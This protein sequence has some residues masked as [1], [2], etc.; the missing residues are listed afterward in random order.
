[1][2]RLAGGL[3]VVLALAL[4]LGTAPLEIATGLV[5]ALALAAMVRRETRPDADFWP[6]LLLLALLLLLSAAGQS[7]APLPAL[8]A[9][10]EPP[11]ALALLVLLPALP[12]DAEARERAARWGLCGAALV[13]VGALAHAL[14]QGQLPWE[15]PE[16][17]LYS[18]HLTLGYALLPPF[19]AALDRRRWGEALGIAAGVV[20]AGSSGPALAM[21]VIGVGLLVGP[22]VALVGGAL[23]AVGLVAALAADPELHER[24]LLWTSGAQLALGRPMGTSVAGFRE[25][26][27]PVQDALSPSFYFPLHAHDAAL[28]AAAVAGLGAWVLWGWL[29]LLLWRRGGRAGRLALAA[30]LVGGLTQDTL[31][32]LEV[33]RALC[34][35]ALL[36]LPPQGTADGA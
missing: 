31:G 35:W 3:L 7:A 36:S 8:R 11:W 23:I 26:V 21:A 24:A 1:M 25:A 16:R 9:A 33:V 18:H 19:A 15:S 14:L 34:F 30:L 29:G 6:P 4:V 12:A 32:D 28:Q 27:A 17:G 13:G 10:L 22:V 20:A 2:R 5:A